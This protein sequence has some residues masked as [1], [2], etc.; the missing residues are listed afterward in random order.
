[1][2]TA[3]PTRPS[4]PSLAPRLANASDPR[5]KATVP[6]GPELQAVLVVAYRA[7]RPVL[8][9][10]P[11]GVGKSE[12][13][14]QTADALGIAA[15]V[16]DLSLL[17]PSDLVGLPV[18]AGGRTTYARPRVLPS[19]GAGILLLEELNRAERYVQQPAL[20]LLSARRLHDYVL[21]EGWCV[22]AA[23]NPDGGDYQVAPMD[24]AL[25]A[26]F[27]NVSVR[28]D[29]AAWISW[30]EANNVHPSVLKLAR[31]H[32]HFLN[33]VAPR[34]WT[35][36]SSLL[37]VLTPKEALDE[38][39]LSHL[40]R[41]YL[42]P[43][44]AGLLLAEK[45]QWADPTG[46]DPY[47]LVRDYHRDG[48][49]QG[50]VRGW[51]DEG[52]TDCF[53]R[54]TERVLSIVG[55]AELGRVA[56]ERQF[57]LESFEALLAD[58]PGDYRERLQRAFGDNPLAPHLIGFDPARIL[59]FRASGSDQVI[60]AWQA[61]PLRQHRVRALATAVALHID[62]APH[63]A[64]LRRSDGARVALGRFLRLVGEETGA[65]LREVL[66]KHLIEPLEG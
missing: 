41:G 33:D 62:H 36:L 2:A 65:A 46:L 27:L 37:Q 44:W 15:E 18:I 19:D 58:V 60:A 34:T 21:P 47:R 31:V 53:D 20:Q 8:L 22:M 25:R 11:T 59:D 14:Q 55:G 7:R 48:A 23:I 12:L 51:A 30:A 6:M 26:R 50:L 63:V 49:L 43:A 61:D 5:P 28:P 1:M 3:F 66:R 42:P 57:S 16:L 64:R 38:Q 13:V 32:D 24:P 10:G 54:V 39:L 40:V 52:R 4:N 56:A 35:Y 9:E 45:A 17:E 29:R